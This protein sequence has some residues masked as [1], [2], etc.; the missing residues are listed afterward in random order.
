MNASLVGHRAGPS[1]LSASR[2]ASLG[3]LALGLV[4]TACTSVAGP[5][6]GVTVVGTGP[7]VTP[8]FACTPEAG[9]TPSPCTQSQYDAMKA[10]DALYAE[11]E[12]VY[13]KFVAEDTKLLQTGGLAAGPVMDLIGG[14]F[15]PIYSDDKAHLHDQRILMSGSPSVAYVRPSQSAL[16]HESDLALAACVDGRSMTATQDGEDA[17]KGIAVRSTVYFKRSEDRLRIWW[18]DGL[19]VDQC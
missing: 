9:G 16:S 5:S 14:P 8:T 11:A 15:A 7:N 12:A 1:P 2:V 17:G 4:L 19:K 10:K 18:F 3:A 6:A 13:R